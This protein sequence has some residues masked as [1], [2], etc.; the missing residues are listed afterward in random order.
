MSSEMAG[1]GKGWEERRILNERRKGRHMK[2]VS[3]GTLAGCTHP[4]FI[5][6]VMGVSLI[7]DG[8]GMPYVVGLGRPNTPLGCA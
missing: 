5:Y 6:M 4:S 7:W 2:T 3:A 1:G 8:E